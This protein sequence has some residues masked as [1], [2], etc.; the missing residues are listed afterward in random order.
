MRAGP[1]RET[2]AM[3]SQTTS[4]F[5]QTYRILVGALMCAPVII[6]LVLAF[7]GST[8]DDDWLTGVPDVLFAG[9][10]LV[11]GAVL[12]ALL[13]ALGYRMEPLGKDAGPRDHRTAQTRFQ[14]A[15]I[16]RFAFA[17]LPVMLGIAL[18]FID[19]SFLLYVIGAVIGLG[20]MAL[21][22][23]P[24]RQVIERSAEVLEVNGV[25]SGLRAE[26]GFAQH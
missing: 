16:L 12:F 25:E 21:H 22:V 19:G 6:G 26:F 23:L 10:L 7:V 18:A 20:L 17:E 2:A 24:T 3:A 5:A 14:S 1:V 11:I 8:G 4:P 15:S 13:P 9:L